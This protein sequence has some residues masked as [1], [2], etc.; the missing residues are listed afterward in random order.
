MCRVSEA[1]TAL[2]GVG[3]PLLSDDAAGIAVARAVHEQ[4]GGSGGIHFIESAVG[5]FELAEMLSG[6]GRAVIIDAIVAPGIAP[7]VWRRVEV[8][9]LA[10]CRPSLNAHYAGLAEGLHIARGLGLRLPQTIRLY[11]IQAADIET[12]SMRLTAPVAAAVPGLVRHILAAEF[13]VAVAP[14]LRAVQ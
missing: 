6:Y 3:N 4:M 9:E 8:S 12:F 10:V 13:S 14:R 1:V 7:G 11:A 2:V 5:G